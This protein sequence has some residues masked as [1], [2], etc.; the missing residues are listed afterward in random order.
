QPLHQNETKKTL[1]LSNLPPGSLA[2]VPSFFVP[3]VSKILSLGDLPEAFPELNGL[4]Q[5]AGHSTE[6]SLLTLSLVI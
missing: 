5:E 6:G 3:R 1:H 2:S 4:F